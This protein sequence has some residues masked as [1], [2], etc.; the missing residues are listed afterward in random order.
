MSALSI[1]VQTSKLRFSFPSRTQLSHSG[2]EEWRQHEKLAGSPGAQCRRRCREW[3]CG[4]ATPRLCRCQRVAYRFCCRAF[5]VAHDS[6]Q[7]SERSYQQIRRA[8]TTAYN[9]N[10]EEPPTRLHRGECQFSAP[11]LPQQRLDQA[12]R[13]RFPRTTLC[14]RRFFVDTFSATTRGS[15]RTNRLARALITATFT[16][17]PNAL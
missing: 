4:R 9:S 5:G 17:L 12:A 2:L 14:R 3:K 16:A 15:S 1:E 11:T 8:R 13:A 6:A 10:G 7:N